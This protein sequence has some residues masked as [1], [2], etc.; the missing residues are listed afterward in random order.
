MGAMQLLRFGPCKQS[1]QELLDLVN[2]IPD[3]GSLD[4]HF[5]GMVTSPRFTASDPNHIR[6]NMCRATAGSPGAKLYPA[7]SARGL[8]LR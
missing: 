3:R 5:G 7:G 1:N 8:P 6:Q 4:L 2:A